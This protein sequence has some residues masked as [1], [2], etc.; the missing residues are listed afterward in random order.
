M[1]E[2]NK[3]ISESEKTILTGRIYPAI[4]SCV[5][6]R[7]KIIVGYFA[8]IGFILS[9]RRL[10]ENAWIK[11]DQ[12]FVNRNLEDLAIGVLWAQAQNFSNIAPLST[13]HCLF[14]YLLGSLE[15]YSLCFKAHRPT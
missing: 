9:A 5:N 12:F 3:K 4:Q 15:G 6:N 14:P 10:S 2:E 1:S 11:D 13:K 8:V 7:Y